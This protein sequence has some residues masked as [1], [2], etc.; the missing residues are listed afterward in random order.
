MATSS[1]QPNDQSDASSRP[2]PNAWHSG[3]LEMQRRAGIRDSPRLRAAIHTEIPQAARAF[4][5]DQRLAV[6][7]T[8]DGDGRP[9][10]SALDGPPG[11]LRTPD[12]TTV[13]IAVGLRLDP[14]V[15]SHLGDQIEVGL[16]VIEP[17]ARRRMRLNG[18]AVLGVE[19][20]LIIHTDEVYSNCPKFIQR[21][22]EAEDL[23]APSQP[24]AP[25]RSSGLSAEQERWIEAA[26]TFF[27]AT[28]HPEAGA[29][30][31]H[32]GGEPG[33][34]RVDGTRLSFPDYRG[35]FL[36]QSLGNILVT[37]RAGLLF[38]DFQRGRSLQLTGQAA[39]D[40][41]TDGR[42]LFASAERVVHVEL[43]EVVERRGA[44]AHSWH[45]V[46]GG[47]AVKIAR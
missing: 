43:E 6:L 28:A 46:E 20:R 34:V 35:N 4:L 41:S 33:F 39:V 21:R 12:E 30:A 31:S 32:R 45:S 22:V 44:L 24:G 27:L 23:P 13:E 7:A 2:K 16:L 47:S 36:F 42:S 5:S 8:L 3:E 40:D 9:W 25:R 19:N 11:F 38:L 29:D 14:L 26:D 15:I 1:A 17:V 18:R 10:A 37:G